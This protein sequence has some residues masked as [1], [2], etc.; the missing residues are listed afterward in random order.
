MD[1]QLTVE[2]YDAICAPVGDNLVSAAAGSGKTKVLSERIVKRLTS[3]DTSIDR[4]LIVTFTR[5][6]AMQMRERIAKALEKEYR[7]HKSDN[8]KRQ[9]SLIAG[10][11]IC[12]I[13][14]F[15]ID[16]VK[17][18]FYLVSV[19][20]DFTI[21]DD[22]EMA[23]LKE[24]IICEVLDEMYGEGDENFLKL[25]ENMGNGKNDNELKETILKVYSFTRAFADPDKWLD[26]AVK[27]HEEG[28]LESQ[29][30]FCELEGEIKEQLADLKAMLKSAMT[31]AL[32]AEIMGYAK[33]FESEYESF[34][35]CFGKN[36]ENMESGFES[37]KFGAFT[38]IKVDASLALEKGI[39]QDMHNEAKA[40]FEKIYELYL[41]TSGTKGISRPKVEALV[42][43]VKL[44]GEKYMEQKLERKELEFSDC[45]YLA[46]KALTLSE[47][48]REELRNKY[49][50]IYIDEYQDT[51]P[52]QDALFTLVSRKERGEPNTFIVGDIKQSIYRFRHSDPMLFAQKA[53]SF[54]Q[55]DKSRKMLLT[56]NFRSR[57]D[58][59]NSVNCVFEKIMREGTAQVEYDEEHRL[60]C[61]RSFVEYNKN[62]S[63]IYV[64][65]GKC[66]EEDSLAGELERE[67]RESLVIA[68]RIREMVDEGFLVSDDDG[69]M[70]P[71]KYSDIAVLTPAIKNKSEM[72]TGAF[73]VMDIPAYSG[74]TKSFFDTTEIRCIVAL[75]K[76]VDNPL[77]DIELAS[78]MRSPLFSFSENELVE[79][80]L[81]GRDKPFYENVTAIS[82][83][84][85]ELGKKC[86]DF[87]QK[88]ERWREL[89][90][91]TSVEKFVT[92]VIDESGYY[93][94]V[95]ALPGGKVRQENIRSFFALANKYEKTQY[96]GLYNFVRYIEKT[97]QAGGGVETTAHENADAV[98][99]TT[100]HRSKGLEFPVVFVMGCGAAFN[101]RDASSAMLMNAVGGIG[102]V[103]RESNRRIKYKTAEYRAIAMLIM[104]ESHAERMRLL[105]VA[106]TRAKEKL[107]LVGSVRDYWKKELSWDL[108]ARGK[109]MS[110]YRIRG[111]NNYL[112]Y[113][114]CSI[115]ER[116]WDVHVVTELPEIEEQK[117]NEK[118]EKKQFER[119][120]EVIKKL[121][122][123]YPFDGI[124]N[125]PSKM[126]VSEIK[127]MSMDTESTAE[128]FDHGKEKR[129]PRFLK[130]DEK[131][132]GALRGT[133]YH[134][135]M[136]LI[137][138][139]EK[140]VKGA[141]EGFVK[142]GFMTPLQA[143]SIEHEKIERF[144]ASHI[145]QRMRN[146]KKIWKEAAFTIE[147][148]AKDVFENGENEKICVQGTIDCL[149]EDENGKLVLLDYKTDFYNDPLEI[150]KR[151]KKQLELYE[152]AVFKRFLR[153][154]HEKCLYLFHKGDT[155]DV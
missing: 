39:L 117:E 126:S 69:K 64:L 27:A 103:E 26:D 145:A 47:D 65:N 122:Y 37:F 112:D 32:D 116:F 154:C 16:L 59:L 42:R 31:E 36:Y 14:S 88:L 118:A 51:N 151:Y 77:C 135:V 119:N 57:S 149:F 120:E 101:D 125:I 98:L 54:G 46:L 38:G 56:K 68:Q 11:D 94:F 66:D 13:D 140:D 48:A 53:K 34:D 105:Y 133:A 12:T 142:N 104:R 97:I 137:D 99:V 155:I 109:K 52:L 78:V 132:T 10:A 49:D 102:L 85:T 7:E 136:E 71:V 76:A 80:R 84:E 108:Y 8:I 81:D 73:A 23:I 18:N 21:A 92:R 153:G 44:F 20:P 19:P 72:I 139:N 111:I 83:T 147:I 129:V 110:D 40:F 58:V 41:V 130:D 96:K 124:M 67:Q 50:E 87:I 106:M 25:A 148:D 6:A 33:V 152:A 90:Y 131:L 70:R 144:I 55:D 35:A 4:L 91:V 93:S 29:G 45:E 100:I 138:L 43:A 146:A 3:G 82:K 62:K 60:K 28:T 17:R 107:I 2:Q 114:M 121:S 150:A 63:E 127:K 75:L 1:V 115:D 61:G 15:C 79:I 30:L 123:M 134:R 95:G 24:E 113:V 22:N 86:K 89:C 74:E 143:E 5:A 9:L 141:I 128:F